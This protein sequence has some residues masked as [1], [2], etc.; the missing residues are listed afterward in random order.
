MAAREYILSIDQGTTGSAAI[1]FDRDGKPAA[2]ADT[3]TRQIF[4]NPGWVEHDPNEIYQTSLQ[5]SRQALDKARVKPS[6]VAG[7]GITNQRETTI[8]WDKKT[9]EPVSNAI[10]WQCRRTAGL[11]EEL[12][13]RGVGQTI[14][15]RTGLI[16]DAYFSA[17][18]VRW[19]L[20]HTKDGQK[21]AEAG[22][23]LFGTVDCWLAW[24]LSGGSA[25]VTDYGN[26]SRTMLFNINTLQWDKDILSTLNI[27]AAILPRV[28]PSSFNY[29]ETA[30]GVFEGVRLPLCAIA[31]DQQAALFGQAC[32]NPGM[33]KNTYG[34][35]SFVLMNSGEQPLISKRGLLTS[36][37]WGLDN[38]VNYTLEG[39]I[40]ITG[41]AIQWLRDGLKIIANAD[42][43]EA[44]ARSVEDNGGVYFVPAFV[45]LGAPYWDMYARGTMIGITRGTTRGHLARATLEAIA[46]QV[47]DVIDTMRSETGI[48][49]PVLRVDGGG[50]ANSFLMQ[51]QADVMNIPIQVA[52]IPE[53]TALGVAYLAGLA[54]GLW[55]SKEEIAGK[56]RSSATF[57]PKMSADLRENLYANWK[58][59]VERARGWAIN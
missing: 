37:A 35:G 15:D 6:S 8:I 49:I 30:E 1:L 36:L 26:A 33:S 52:A 24:K 29:G 56:W 58:R 3:E 25:H 45:G 43:S 5:V 32:Y 17:T 41:A 10:V 55:K 19:I 54:A 34:T 16:P 23:L 9:G 13:N 59:A 12:K 18:K 47:R 48:G 7:I 50:T 31:G 42:E 14:C 4:P 44:L 38:K 40:F 2:D 21:R 53:T 28:I 39:S 57:E 11:V 46:F 27:P 51:F 20:D 22:D